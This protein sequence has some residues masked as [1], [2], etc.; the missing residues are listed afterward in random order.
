MS[1]VEHTIVEPGD[2]AFTDEE[3]PILRRYLLN[4]GFLMCDDFWGDFDSLRR[5]FRT[6]VSNIPFYGLA[7]CC[8]DHPE[9]ANLLSR[10]KDR[11]VVTYGFSASADLRAENVATSGALTFLMRETF[12]AS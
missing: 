9:V 1:N 7:V 3:V 5:G 10:I 8:I 2:L 12:P 6:F 4:G 11:R